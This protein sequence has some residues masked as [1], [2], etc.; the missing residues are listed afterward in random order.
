MKIEVLVAAMNQNIVE[1]IKKM[2]LSTDAIIINQCDKFS[3]EEVQGKINDKNFLIKAYSL[4]ER[5]VGLSRNSAFM[6]AD[7]DICLFSDEDIRYVDDY[8]TL[9]IKEFEQNPH[10]DMIMFEVEREEERVTCHITERKRVRQYNCGRYGAVNIAVKRNKLLE[11]KI[12]FSLLFGGGA[13]YSA[14]EDSLF[15]KECLDK[16]L[17]IYTA[18]IPIGREE[19]SPSSWFQGYHKK[20]FIDRGVLYHYL[21]GKMATLLAI[22]FLLSHKNKMCKEVSLSQAYHYMQ[23][24]IKEAR[25]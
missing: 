10:A 11:K 25:N 4:K 6:R 1:L 23:D 19:E 14:G 22:R 13:K 16:G 12:T 3:Y 5:G 20:F 21:Y 15:I 17:K 9:I 8:E 2:N 24:G 18:P 7:R